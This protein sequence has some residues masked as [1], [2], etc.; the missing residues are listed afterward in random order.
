MKLVKGFVQKKEKDLKLSKNEFKVQVECAEI[1]ANYSTRKRWLSKRQYVAW[2]MNTLKCITKKKTLLRLKRNKITV[3][4]RNIYRE[5]IQAQLFLLGIL[6]FL[7]NTICTSPELCT[8]QICDFKMYGAH[9]LQ[10]G[11]RKTH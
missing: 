9:A 6:R 11:S 5:Y 8:D 1:N 7:F 2:K 10:Q 4:H 3:E